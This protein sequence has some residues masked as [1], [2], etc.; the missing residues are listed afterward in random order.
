MAENLSLHL[1]R[2]GAVTSWTQLPRRK[3]GY[4]GDTRIVS[5]LY[6]MNDALRGSRNHGSGP[7]WCAR[8]RMPRRVHYARA[9][10]RAKVEKMSDHVVPHFHNDAGVPIIEIGS[11]EF[12]CVGANPPFD[13]P[14]VFLDLGNDNEIIC[15]YCSTLYRFAAD[16][17]AGAV[18]SAGMRAERQGRL[19]SG[20]DGAAHHR[21]RWCGHRRT[22]GRAGAGRPRA[23]ASSF[24]RRP[25]RLEE[26]GAGL[27]L[28]PNASRIL[29]DLGLQPR[30]APHVTTPGQ[31]QHHDARAAAA[32]WS[33][34]RSAKP[35]T[36]AMAR[37]TGW[38]TAPICNPHCSARST[39]HPDIELRLGCPSIGQTSRAKGPT[40]DQRRVNARQQESALALD[41]RRRHRGPSVRQ[42]LFPEA[43]P[44]F[45]GLHRLARHARRDAGCRANSPRHGVQLWMGPNA[46][47]VAYP[48]SSARADQRGRD[49]A[50]RP[51]NRPGWS[52]AGDANEIKPTFCIAALARRLRAMH[53]RRRR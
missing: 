4:L 26:A 6:E 34:C 12:M 19:I 25:R 29:V 33:A 1:F 37:P 44:Q 48:M 35:A 5:N 3:K 21:H 49:R 39:T 11:Q 23:F 47:L 45:S 17:A 30:L 53:D 7:V 31:C 8:T 38:C 52:D 41:R 36:A 13:H 28:S 22:D 46:H 14:H 20:R 9:L 43:Q 32:R 16:L 40:G 51:A 24:W 18:T 15:P 2:N 50:G 10:L 42:Q 27:Q